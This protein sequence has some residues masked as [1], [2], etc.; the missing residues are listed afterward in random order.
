L[1]AR[2]ELLHE[3]KG[4]LVYCHGNLISEDLFAVNRAIFTN[5]KITQL[6]YCL[7]DLTDIHSLEIS[8]ENLLKLAR[9]DKARLQMNPDLRLAFVTDH[10]VV[11]SVVSMWSGYIG[12]GDRQVRQFTRRDEAFDWLEQKLPEPLA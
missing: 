1:S 8:A 10:D 5:D 12:L 9:N 4:V 3:G 2:F 7:I 11:R 6:Q